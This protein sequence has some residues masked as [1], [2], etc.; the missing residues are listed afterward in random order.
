MFRDPYDWVEA[1]RVEPHHAHNHLQWFRPYDPTKKV[2]DMAKPLSWKE[3]VTKPWIGKR[4]QHDRKIRNRKGGIANATCMDRYSF[5]DAAPCSKKDSPY[6]KGLGDYKYE[7]QHD[8]SERGF[9]SIIDLR[10]EKIK[11]M[12]SV[13]N[14]RGTKALFPFRYEDLNFNGTSALLKSLEESTGFKAKCNAT[15]GEG[16]RQI[17]EKRIS[18][19]DALP[20]D[21]MR[22]M[23]RYVDWETEDQIGYSRRGLHK[24]A[25]SI[26]DEISRTAVDPLKP[27]MPVEQIILLGERHS[28]TNWITDYLTGCF[29]IKVS[30]TLI[31]LI[32]SLK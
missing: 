12:L 18:K 6:V 9:S 31:Q 32:F 10:R 16:H 21:F 29:D 2:K 3:F 14:F 23:N 11:N 17:V 26:G 30:K 7:L 5:R 8:G 28:G 22:W 4:G 13:A 1:M 25:K 15:L 19:H 27:T 24:D 20:G